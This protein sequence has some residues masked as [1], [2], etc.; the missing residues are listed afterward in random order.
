MALVR[1]GRQQEI[2]GFEQR[3]VYDVRPRWEATEKGH[4]V[5]GVR[6]VDTMKNGKARCRLVCQDFNNDKKKTDE[7]FAPSPPLVARVPKEWAGRVL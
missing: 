7:M 3:R 1:E 6:W 2:K 4:K 5:V